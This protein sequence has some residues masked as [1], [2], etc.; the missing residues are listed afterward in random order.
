MGLGLRYGPVPRNIDT[1]WK[2]E[3]DLGDEPSQ[4][5]GSL[6]TCRPQSLRC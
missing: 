3:E 1:F 5:N 6:L 2:I 4:G